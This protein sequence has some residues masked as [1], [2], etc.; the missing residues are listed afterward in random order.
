[1]ANIDRGDYILEDLH[2]I[3]VGPAVKLEAA[4]TINGT[5]RTWGLEYKQRYRD[6]G[7]HMMLIGVIGKSPSGSNMSVTNDNGNAKV[8]TTAY[9]PPTGAMEDAR[10]IITAL[11]GTVGKGPWERSGIAATVHPT[12][13]CP[14]GAVVR[15]S[16]L[17]V[18][19]NPGLYVV[20]G[21]VLPQTVMRNPSN[22][23]AAVAEKAMD[24]MLGVPGA[25]SW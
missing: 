22:T 18:Y 5:D 11:G 23:I 1:M 24:V 25:P 17:Q 9:Y 2:A 13:G 19:N 14:M 16:D 20:D 7:Q 8:S 6:Y 12:G 4:F 3:P 15:P 21:S 10:A